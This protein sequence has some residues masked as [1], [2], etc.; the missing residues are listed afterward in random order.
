MNAA[1]NIVVS[2][3][4]T[5]DVDDDSSVYTESI[6]SFHSSES[7]TGSPQQALSWIPPQVKA[8]TPSFHTSFPAT[9]NSKTATNPRRRSPLNTKTSPVRKS[10]NSMSR[11]SCR[12]SLLTAL[13]FKTRQIQIVNRTASTLMC[14]IIED[15]RVIP[16]SVA[17]SPSSVAAGG[18]VVAVKTKLVGVASRIKKSEEKREWSATNVPIDAKCCI[19][20]IFLCEGGKYFRSDDYTVRADHVLMLDDISVYGEVTFNDISSQ[21]RAMMTWI[22]L[23]PTA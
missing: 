17:L 20:S 7:N 13:G 6:H 11:K 2:N 16:T 9:P 12:R 21:T 22:S 15:Q 23:Q 5:T 19:V 4:G 14:V 18:S 8:Q 3:N 1:E 10:D